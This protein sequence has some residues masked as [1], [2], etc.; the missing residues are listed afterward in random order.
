MVSAWAMGT[1]CQAV[2]IVSPGSRTMYG[3]Q[4]AELRALWPQLLP[5]PGGTAVG[6]GAGRLEY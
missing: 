4:G 2:A 1:I 5:T 6:P 3:T